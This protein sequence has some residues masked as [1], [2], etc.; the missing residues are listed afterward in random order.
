ML[1]I[2]LTS[3]NDEARMEIFK[4][5]GHLSVTVAATSTTDNQH[6]LVRLLKK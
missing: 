1:F 3:G 4:T 6:S 2:L 5:I